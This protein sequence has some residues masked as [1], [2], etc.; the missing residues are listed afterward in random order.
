MMNAASNLQI[1]YHSTDKRPVFTQ[2]KFNAAASA[3]P[4][5]GF[6]QDFAL[7]LFVVPSLWN[8]ITEN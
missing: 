3:R 6:L 2:P 4:Q 8:A 1:L 5:S 7:V